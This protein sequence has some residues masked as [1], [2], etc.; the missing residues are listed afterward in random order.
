MFLWNLN[1]ATLLGMVSNSD[2]RAAYSIVVPGTA[3]QVDTQSTDT[4]ERPLYWM[5][6]DA[7]RPEE[8]LATYGC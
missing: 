1:F 2:E 3:C 8:N 7:V 5:L 4:T 6:Y